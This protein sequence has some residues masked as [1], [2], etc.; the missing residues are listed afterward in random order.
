MG[1]QENNRDKDTAAKKI[2]SLQRRR[3]AS[4]AMWEEVEGRRRSS[5]NYQYKKSAYQSNGV[6]RNVQTPDQTSAL[7]NIA[8]IMAAPAIMYVAIEMAVSIRNLYGEILVLLIALSVD[9]TILISL[10]MGDSFIK[11]LTMIIAVIVVFLSIVLLAICEIY[12]L[13]LIF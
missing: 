8:C 1:T 2:I 11:K 7:K 3:E 9:I 6:K 5:Q 10:R 12:L 4:D 13:T